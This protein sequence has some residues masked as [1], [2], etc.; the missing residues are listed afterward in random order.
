ME[1]KG[2]R[3]LTAPKFD[4]MGMSES[5]WRVRHRENFRLGKKVETGSFALIPA[6]K[7]SILKMIL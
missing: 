2:K 3:I 6:S 4:E 1:E 7:R 5:R